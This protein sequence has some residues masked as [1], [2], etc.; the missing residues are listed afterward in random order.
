MGAA[1]SGIIAVIANM[2]WN[3]VAASSERVAMCIGSSTSWPAVAARSHTCLPSALAQA[4]PRGVATSSGSGLHFI[5]LAF[6]FTL[7]TTVHAYMRANE[8]VGV[9]GHGGVGVAAPVIT[10]E[11]HRFTG[12]SLFLY[13]FLLFLFFSAQHC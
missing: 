8:G 2:K 12:L 5:A 1:L 10:G 9:G 4:E 13:S 7:A 6:H 3:T 11:G